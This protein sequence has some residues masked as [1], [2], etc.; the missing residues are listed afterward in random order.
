MLTVS[1]SN[2]SLEPTICVGFSF[3]ADSIGFSPDRCS[4]IPDGLEQSSHRLFVIIQWVDG[5]VVSDSQA[6]AIDA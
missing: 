6:F 3:K 4:H 2:L 1:P 5:G